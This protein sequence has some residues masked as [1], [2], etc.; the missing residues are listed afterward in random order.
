MP[1]VS[2]YID[3]DTLVKIEQ[4]AH[5]SH[6]SISKWVGNNLKR[7]IKDDYPDDYFELFGA[8]R[9]SSFT[10]PENLSFDADIKRMRI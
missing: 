2:L 1:Q 10:R 7:L 6:T 8:I 5:K 3:K 4:L 9:D